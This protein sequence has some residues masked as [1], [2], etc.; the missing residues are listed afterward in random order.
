MAIL[1]GIRRKTG[2]L[3]VFVAGALVLFLIQGFADQM[4]SFWK[5]DDSTQFKGQ[6]GSVRIKAEEF[7]NK[8][9]LKEALTKQNYANR[10]QEMPSYMINSLKQQV[11]NDYVHENAFLPVYEKAG[12]IV[13]KEGHGNSYSEKL[14]LLKGTTVSESVK[15]NFTEPE[16]EFDPEN[17]TKYLESIKAITDPNQKQF[18]EIQ[19][20]EFLN[21]LAQEREQEKFV[22]LFSKTNYVTQEEAKRKHYEDN[23]TVD[24]DYVYIPL[25]SMPDSAV[26]FTDNDLKT[27]LSQ[28]RNFF[29]FTDG[30]VLDYVVFNIFP[31]G[32]DTSSA[33]T[34][35][36]TA[37]TEFRKTK[38]DTSFYKFNSDRPTQP[39][40]YTYEQ[41]PQPLKEDSAYLKVGYV[42]GPIFE[43]D[44]Y[45]TYK[46][47]GTEANE[48]A[49]TAHILINYGTDTTASQTKAQGILAR[50]RA[51]EDFGALAKEFSEDPGSKDKNGEYPET[52][53]GSGWVKPFED[54]VFNAKN[55]G[56][57]RELVETQFGFHIMKILKTATPSEKMIVVKISKA[58]TP[59]K[60]TRD[61]VLLTA[62]QFKKGV[63]KG[64]DLKAKAEETEGVEIV[65]SGL[66]N[67][68]SR[69]VGSVYN[70]DNIVNWA[71]NTERK[72]GDVSNAVLVPSSNKF[73]IASLKRIADKNNPQIDDARSAIERSLYNELKGK[74]LKEK[75][76]ATDGDLHERFNKLN[77]ENGQGYAKYNTVKGQKFSNNGVTGV[78]TEPAM[79]GT[80]IA[81]E[82]EVWSK[83]L[84]GQSG[85]YIVRTNAKVEA[86]EVADYNSQKTTLENENTDDRL[87]V[88]NAIKDHVGVK[89]NEK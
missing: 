66:L 30:R 25:S 1:E 24:F 82:N 80:A 3:L 35:A 50:A 37:A 87:S 89:D 74:A 17:I 32:E 59:S 9:S 85:V 54:A 77:E 60:K 63:D 19:L 69:A 67:P 53:K 52:S 79:V 84:V 45:N 86:K 64:E 65:E 22:S 20:T 72:V 73:V 48:V 12:I 43:A 44:N 61:A 27:H 70:A 51:G 26:S 15:Q 5:A 29:T 16:K 4:L 40:A 39:N 56:V 76:S 83:T 75:L 28:N 14:D 68:S 13:T 34:A 2:L 33:F 62:S 21:G 47:I 23:S 71:F 41:L 18:Q 78:G 31:S 7:N 8:V 36:S 55:T 10:G 58:I 6:I 11:W 49:Q 81:Q 88:S 38:N 57:L 46:I 42:K